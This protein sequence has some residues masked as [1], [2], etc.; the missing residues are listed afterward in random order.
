MELAKE[1]GQS[2]STTLLFSM[3]AGV[4]ATL[5]IYSINKWLAVHGSHTAGMRAVRVTVPAFLLMGCLIGVRIKLKSQTRIASTAFAGAAAA[6]GGIA[7]GV[8]MWAKVEDVVFRRFGTYPI[9]EDHN[10]W[11]AEIII[12]WATAAIP[13]VIGIYV[14]LAAVKL[15]AVVATKR[16]GP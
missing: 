11:P 6:Y 14:G 15:A 7:A 5:L 13:M 9:Y 8:V 2:W 16:T 3:L 10:L 4:G 1:R 12:F